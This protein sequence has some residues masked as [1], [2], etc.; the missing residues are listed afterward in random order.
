MNQVK[1][2]SISAFL[3][4]L[5]SHMHYLTKASCI[6]SKTCIIR[7]TCNFIRKN[8]H[9]LR[10]TKFTTLYSNMWW[11]NNIK[12]YPWGCWFYYYLVWF[13]FCLVGF[14]QFSICVQGWAT[15][16][17]SHCGL[18]VTG[19]DFDSV[20]TYF[21]WAGN[22]HGKLT[23][24][25]STNLPPPTYRPATNSASSNKGHFGILVVVIPLVVIM[26]ACLGCVAYCKIRTG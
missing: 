22:P 2:V 12:F 11:L 1:S 16:F 21:I 19:E 5:N 26:V 17:Y 15:C 6:T 25:T 13:V 14:E 9:Y 24:Q 4:K 8:M 10:K 20:L 7:Q 18:P 23:P 3:T